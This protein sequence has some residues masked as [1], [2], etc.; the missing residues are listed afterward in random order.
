MTLGKELSKYKPDL[1]RVQE[2]WWDRGGTKPAGEYTFFYGKRN[3]KHELGTGFFVPKRIMSTI[4]RVVF[5][6]DRTLYIPLKG[7]CD[8]IVLNFMPQ[9]RIK[10]MMWKRFYKKLECVFDSFSI[11]H[12]QKKNS[13][14]F[15][16]QV[17]YTDWAA[18]TCRRHLAPTFA[19]RGVS[20]GQCS[21]FP[22]VINLSFLDWSCYFS[23]K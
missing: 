15:S 10:L 19:E 7:H 5:V 14:A 12:K 13:V 16:L 4:K 8:I 18:A 6:T 11:Y 1:V 9:Q 3:A 17:N 20:C 2:V 23:F 21:R 22:V